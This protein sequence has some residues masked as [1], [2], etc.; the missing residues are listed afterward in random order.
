MTGRSRCQVRVHRLTAPLALVLAF[1]VACG[2]D[3]SGPG[4]PT[5][6][7]LMGFSALPPRP[8]TAILL[9]TLTLA[10]QHADAGLIQLSIPW[11]TLLDGVPAPVEVRT[12]R[13]PLVDFYRGHGQAI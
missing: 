3:P 10:A 1:L 12:V 7:Y 6:S 4:R 8:D 11:Q 13:L 9:P 2:S 5:R